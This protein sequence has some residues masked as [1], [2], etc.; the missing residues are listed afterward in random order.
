MRATRPLSTLHRL[1]R[2]RRLQ[3]VTMHRYPWWLPSLF[4]VSDLIVRVTDDAC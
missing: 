2:R 3:V 4:R 1:R